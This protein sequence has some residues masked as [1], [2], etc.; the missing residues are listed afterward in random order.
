MK[1]RLAQPGAV[2]LIALAAVLAGARIATATIPDANGTVHGCVK[3][4]KGQLYLIDPSAGETCGQKDTAL[5][6][7]KT[8]ETG[9]Q[10]ATGPKGVTGF[11]GTAGISGYEKMSDTEPTDGTGNGRAEADCSSGKVA[12]AGGYE[13]SSTSTLIPLHS[14]PTSDG[15][16]WVVDVT[17]ALNSAVTAFAICAKNGGS[18]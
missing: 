6:W 11:Q 8:G 13:L 3:Q 2:A 1:R 16:G 5:D 4:Q 17:G 14:A 7:N 15:S 18:S 10:G 12:L 9:I